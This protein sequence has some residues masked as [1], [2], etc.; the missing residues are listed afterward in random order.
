MKL[1]GNLKKQV[2]STN[3]KEEAKE[4]SEKAGMD[5]TD[6]ELNNV[7]GGFHFF[8]SGASGGRVK[9]CECGNPE[10]GVRDAS[11]GELTCKNC[12][13]RLIVDY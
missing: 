13:G 8:V 11:S 4:V 5:L 9:F 10:I 2:E 3:S 1:I 12:G 7:T 6:D